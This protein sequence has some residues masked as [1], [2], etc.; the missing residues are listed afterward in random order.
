MTDSSGTVVWSADYKPFGE[1]T[2]TIS[3]ITNNLRFPGQYYDAET[4]L[5]YNY[6]RDYNPVIG[7]YVEADRIGLRGGMNLYVYVS[8][9]PTI[10]ID[11]MG[12]AC[13]T[14]DSIP[15][16]ARRFIPSWMLNAASRSCTTICRRRVCLVGVLVEQVT[17][18]QNNNQPMPDTS[19][20]N[21]NIPDTPNPS[22]P[23]HN[24]GVSYNIIGLCQAMSF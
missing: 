4:G 14:Y 11:P 7:R 10:Y 23:N 6:Y 18:N 16:G 15:S 12:E 17:T 13:Y 20:G 21:S 24:A 8:N 2:V 5:N 19:S 1:A 9:R 3:T 22:D